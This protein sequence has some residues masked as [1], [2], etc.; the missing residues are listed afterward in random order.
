MSIDLL[1]ESRRNYSPLV[2][3]AQFHAFHSI[4]SYLRS[5]TMSAEA[6]ALQVAAPVND[7]DCKCYVDSI[8]SYLWDVPEVFWSI[9]GQIP[10]DH[11]WQDKLVLTLKAL[12]S[13]PSPDRCDR[14]E[15][16]HTWGSLWDALPVFGAGT[17]EMWNNAPFEDENDPS[18][19]HFTAFSPSAWLNCNAFQAR[20][21]VALVSCF[22][23]YAMWLFRHCLE[24][25]HRPENLDINIPA[26]AMWVHFAGQR[27]YH[28]AACPHQ[29]EA[30]T[31]FYHPPQFIVPFSKNRWDFWIGQLEVVQNYG[32]L[33]AETRKFAADALGTMQAIEEKEPEPR[34]E[35]GERNWPNF[36]Y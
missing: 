7:P 24:E 23:L 30:K 27:L 12:K 33:K 8:E 13:V 2:L 4:N 22:D 26:L 36:A 9:A 14:E 15:C 20:I 34:W 21:T 6:A 25:E 31:T 5:E 3:E 29:E 1:F 10:F 18:Q 35:P 17:R 19:Q 28:N 32:A 16:E 11:P